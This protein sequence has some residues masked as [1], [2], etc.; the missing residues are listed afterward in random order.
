MFFLFVVIMYDYINDFDYLWF[1]IRFCK[2]IVIKYID[3][4]SI[5]YFFFKNLMNVVIEINL[6]NDILKDILVYM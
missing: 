1:V 3:N 2:W 5:V 6:R 4:M